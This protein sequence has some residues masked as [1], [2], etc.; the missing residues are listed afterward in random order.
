MHGVPSTVPATDRSTS[1]SSASSCPP[2]RM[3]PA[4]TNI[5][6]AGAL[7]LDSLHIHLR[8]DLATRETAR[9][10]SARRPE[11]RDARPDQE[12]LPPREARP[13]QGAQHQGPGHPARLA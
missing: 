6:W 11:G 2:R 4:A 13:Q 5:A 3:G 8:I 1:T 9:Y 7:R 10:K 12:A